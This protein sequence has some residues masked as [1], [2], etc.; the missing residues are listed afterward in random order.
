MVKGLLLAITILGSTSVVTA[1]T[2]L[3][4]V[5]VSKYQGDIDYQLVAET[6]VSFVFIKATEGITYQDQNFLSNFSGFD[7]VDLVVGA[8]HFYE[9]NDDPNEQLD[10]FITTVGDLSG[11]FPPVIDVET[12]HDIENAATLSNDLV[13]FA[14]GLEAYYGSKPILYSSKSFANSYLIDFSD[15]PLWLAEYE[16]AEPEIPG[17]WETWAFWQWSQSGTIEGLD[18]Y[19]DQN[20]FNGSDLSELVLQ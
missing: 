14:E 3:A 15:Y 9:S 20:W 17:N 2:Y 16:V 1:E 13:A 19:V 18:G 4:G 11:H 8:Y 10:K 6:G 7:D 5:D 12:L